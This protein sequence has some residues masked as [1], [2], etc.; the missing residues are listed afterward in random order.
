MIVDPSALLA[1]LR[2][3]EDAL[4]YSDALGHAV[5]ARISAA[6]Y[7]EGALVIDQNRNPILSRKFDDLIKVADLQIEPVTAEHAKI[8]RQAYRDYGKASGHPAALNFGDCFS[9]ALARE[10]GLPLLFKGTDFSHTDL[11]L[12]KVD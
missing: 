3:E 11:E 12:V 1:I 7:L 10:T 4:A 6:G 8:A 9:Y 5:N 2:E